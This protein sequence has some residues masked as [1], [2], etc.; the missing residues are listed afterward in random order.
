MEK[1]PYGQKPP[2]I[3]IASP[4]IGAIAKKINI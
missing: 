2:L 3:K 1:S 4:Y